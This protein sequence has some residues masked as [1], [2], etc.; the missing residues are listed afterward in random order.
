METVKQTKSIWD[1]IGIAISSLCL[2]HC[3]ALPLIVMAFPF[4]ELDHDHTHELFLVAIVAV[5]FIAF[6]PSYK[7]H[8]QKK[9]LLFAGLGISSLLASIFAGHELGSEIG[10]H[11]LSIVGSLLLITA[12]VKNIKC[13]HA[14]CAH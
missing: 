12:H 13:T 8:G 6:L 10:E 5:V 1:K 4:L 3:I 11:V 2:V 9:I 14:Q 7:K